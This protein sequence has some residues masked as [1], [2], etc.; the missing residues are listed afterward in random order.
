M[1]PPRNQN[2]SRTLPGCVLL[3]ATNKKKKK[4]AAYRLWNRVLQTSK[5]EAWLLVCEQRKKYIKMLEK[6]E[7]VKTKKREEESGVSHFV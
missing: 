3:P 2:A 7:K 6:G 4:R 1:N 5:A